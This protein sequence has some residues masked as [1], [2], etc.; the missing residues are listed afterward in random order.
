MS[1]Q[2]VTGVNLVKSL[3]LHVNVILN[4]FI[5]GMENVGEEKRSEG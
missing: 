5:E 1:K 2:Q 4:L 3:P